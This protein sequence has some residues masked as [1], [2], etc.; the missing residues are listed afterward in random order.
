MAKLEAGMNDPARMS[1]AEIENEL[2]A[3]NA[4]LLEARESGDKIGE[5]EGRV[6][7]LLFEKRFRQ[8]NGVGRV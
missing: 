3:A 2:R 5:L 7:R 6:F 8:T 1:L 4:K